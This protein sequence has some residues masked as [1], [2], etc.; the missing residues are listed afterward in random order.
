MVGRAEHRPDSSA[1]QIDL[2]AD[3]ANL[4]RRD[5]LG[6]GSKGGVDLGAGPLGTHSRLG[7]GY[8][9]QPFPLVHHPPPGLRLEVL[10][11]FKAALVEPD[12]LRDSIVRADDRRVAPGVSGADI[13]SFEDGDIG[14]S[15]ARRQI[16][17]CRESVSAS[18]NDHDVIGPLR[19]TATSVRPFVRQ[20]RSSAVAPRGRRRRAPR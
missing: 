12:R 19:S 17:G 13:F 20:I 18:A 9:E 4:A 15:V 7:M 11:E 2:R 14:D 10:V 6:P 16:V 5:E 1:C 3:L 8:P